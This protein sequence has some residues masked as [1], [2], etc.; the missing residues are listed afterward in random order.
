M[1]IGR[2]TPCP[3]GSGKK[4]KKCCLDKDQQAGQ[5]HPHKDDIIQPHPQEPVRKTRQE[6][7]GNRIRPYVIAK[8]CDP[9]GKHVQ[10]V[11]SRRPELSEKN[12]ISV[13]QIR[14]LPTEQI[15]KQLS[16]RGISYDQDPFIAMCEKKDSAWDVAGMLWP[17]QAKSYSKDVSDIVCM[18]ACILWE[19][20]YE[21]KKITRVS[22]E[23]LDDWMENGYKQLDEDRFDA[24]RIWMRVWE[25]FKNDYDLASNSIKNIE[26]QFNGSQS[27][28]NWCQDF[29]MELINASIDSKEYADIGVAYLK[30]F[31]A[32][33]ADEDDMFINQFKSSLGEFYCRSGDQAAGEEMM[34]ELIRQYPDKAFGY[35]GMEIAFSIRELNGQAP[36]HVE[37]LKILEDAKKYPVIDGES[38]DLD[39]RISHLKKEM[40]NLETKRKQNLP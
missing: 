33:F 16:E 36:A 20:L 18:A 39:S 1:K 14:S 11:L 26:A 37:R 17:K 27:F 28:F 29:E 31:I 3:C 10:D 2:N 21:E 22:V 38:F 9:T 12:K 23:M 32:C 13:S 24:C 30:D 7:S 34:S 40:A 4:Y 19:R 25:T 8:M 5:K 15:I 6:D 35:I